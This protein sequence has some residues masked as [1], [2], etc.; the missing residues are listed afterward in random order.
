MLIIIADPF[1]VYLVDT[2]VSMPS[3]YPLAPP[4]AIR[5]TSRALTPISYNQTVVLQCLM[6]GA[7]SPVLIIRKLDHGTTV[8]GGDSSVGISKYAHCTLGEV[9]GDLISHLHK[10]AFE[11][12]DTGAQAPTP[13][14]TGV[15][16]EFLSCMDLK[17]LVNTYRP[18]GSRKWVSSTLAVSPTEMVLGSVSSNENRLSSLPV[19]LSITS[20]GGDKGKKN[21][22]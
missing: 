8:V 19:T 13:G 10:V 15:S 9:C 18:L 12:F 5:S 2:M 4:N 21:G 6:S 22:V 3:Q 14:T 1:I 17:S 20:E 7:V 11:V 16:G